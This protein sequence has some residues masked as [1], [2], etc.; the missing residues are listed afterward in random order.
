[1]GIQ[2]IE[3]KTA[4]IL[5]LQI[6]IQ[7]HSISKFYAVIHLLLLDRQVSSHYILD[8]LVRSE[9]NGILYYLLFLASMYS[10]NS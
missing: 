7:M 2:V 6:C 10:V 1:M 9:E 5:I 8:T 3:M 4:Q